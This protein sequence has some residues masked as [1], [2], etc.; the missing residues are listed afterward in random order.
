MIEEVASSTDKTMLAVLR[1]IAG[2]EI[3]S[4]NSAARVALELEEQFL[5]R[6]WPVGD[7]VGNV[8]DLRARMSMGRWTCREALGILQMRGSASMRR[9]PGGGLIVAAPTFDQLVHSI[10]MHLALTHTRVDDVFLT[11]GLLYAAAVRM[12]IKADL[13]KQNI[14]Q[15]SVP[16]GTPRS[17]PLRLAAL[18]GNKSLTFFIELLEALSS[19]ALSSAYGSIEHGGSGDYRAQQE[20]QLIAA[21]MANDSMRAGDLAL[22][23]G[24]PR[25]LIESAPL[26]LLPAISLPD[27]LRE[28]SYANRLA[29]RLV[30]DILRMEA[31][32]VRLGTEQDIA[33]RYGFHQEVVRQAVRIIESIGLVYSQRGRG[34]GLRRKQPPLGPAIRQI[35]AYL[36][37]IRFDA[38]QSHALLLYLTCEASAVAAR[39]ANSDACE[40]ALRS[41]A[42]VKETGPVLNPHALM[43]TEHGILNAL[44]NPALAICM[45]S[46]SFHHSWLTLKRDSSHS[47]LKTNFSSS[48]YFDA[49]EEVLQAIAAGD[50]LGAR[51]AQEAK[52]AGPQEIS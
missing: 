24:K 27:E 12:C 19:L 23:F 25:Y 32:D 22:D 16:D 17:L 21:M 4:K 48:Q 47:F 45:H 44:V 49:A 2:G 37:A 36:A 9:G 31:H 35:A 14:A 51:Q 13:P 8:E 29:A 10:Y 7:M 26:G 46:L 42:Q 11:R 41:I 5:I 20:T 33:E 43:Q 39:N 28:T 40:F 34:G 52:N 38:E 15:L 50:P 6:G 30:L 1:E 18:L 3:F